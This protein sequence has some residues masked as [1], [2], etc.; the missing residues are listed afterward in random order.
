[1]TPDSPLAG[2]AQIGELMGSYAVVPDLQCPNTYNQYEAYLEEYISLVKGSGY[3]YLQ[4]IKECLARTVDVA[5]LLDVDD[6]S[7]KLSTLC[8][9]MGVDFPNEW[10]TPPATGEK[11]GAN[12]LF[13]CYFPPEKGE[14]VISRCWVNVVMHLFISAMVG[15]S[16]LHSDNRDWF[17][18]NLFRFVSQRFMPAQTVPSRRIIMD[19]FELDGAIKPQVCGF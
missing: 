5:S 13:A 12:Y 10:D 19:T 11:K 14:P 9:R 8:R 4:A 18:V 1:M 3:T 15:P 2:L 16:P 6:S 17:A 7:V